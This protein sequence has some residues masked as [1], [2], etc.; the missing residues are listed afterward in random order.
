MPGTLLLTL[1]APQSL[2]PDLAA[3]YRFHDELAAIPVRVK[4]PILREI[5]RQWWRESVAAIYEGHPFPRTDL[6]GALRDAVIRHH[7]TRDHLDAMIAGEES[8]VHLVYLTLE[9]V[10]VREGPALVAARPIGLAYE[11]EEV[12]RNLAA[13]RALAP[14]I[15]KAARPALRLATLTRWRNHPLAAWALLWAAVRG[16]Y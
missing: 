4:E 2:R 14:L 15:P 5:R 10:G 9:V 1:F 6:L 12:A 11:G 7:L 3:L 16:R 8:A 13:A